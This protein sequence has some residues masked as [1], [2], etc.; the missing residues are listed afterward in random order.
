LSRQKSGRGSSPAP[1]KAKAA[2]PKAARPKA[3]STAAAARARG[4]YVQTPRSDV[5]VTLLGLSLGAMLLA[6]LFMFL[7]WSKYEMKTKPTASLAQASST[8]LA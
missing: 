3:A 6:C 4:V 1:A 8:A 7:V 5:Y 2:K